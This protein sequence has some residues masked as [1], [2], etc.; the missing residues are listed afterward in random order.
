MGLYIGV[1]SGTSMDGVDAVLCDISQ[2][3][4]ITRA[5]ASVPYPPHL[6]SRLHALCESVSFDIT[7]LAQTDREVALCFADAVN[8]LLAQT[9]LTPSSVRAIG[10]HGQTIR[11]Y[12]DLTPGITLQLGDLNTLA[13]QTGIATIGDFRR[14]D[15]ALGGQGAPLAPAFHAF[16]FQANDR[17]RVLVNIGGIAN[18]SVL[19][20][21]DTAS[22]IIGF[23]TGP[24]NTLMDAW[25]RTHRNQPY[26]ASG[27]WARSGTVHPQL[28]ASLLGDSYFSQPA[29]KSTGRERFNPHWLNTALA[30]LDDVPKPEDVQATLLALTAESIVSAIA[31]VL[32]ADREADIVVCGGGAFNQTLM[33]AIEQ[34]MTK[35]LPHAQLL[36]TGDLGIDP[37]SVEGAAFA[38]LAWA[39]ENNQAGNLPAVTGASQPAVLGV[40]CPAP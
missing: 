23:D 30:S 17:Y 3:G 13:A 15:I 10:S 39:Y 22:D 16:Q 31:G 6:L 26:D 2:T 24:G 27:N 28:L 7:L 34:L 37:Q 38:W 14:K 11:H 25:C 8:T 35:A 32:S 36:T 12:P 19:P 1:M 18:I 33:R 40:Y 20:P 29:P 21:A 9:G 4:C 5:Q